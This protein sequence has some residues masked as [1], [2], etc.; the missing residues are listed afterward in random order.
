M[1][2]VAYLWNGLVIFHAV[3]VPFSVLM[4]LVERKDYRSLVSD[5][6]RVGAMIAWYLQVSKMVLG[7]TGAVAG[8]FGV[9][10]GVT[11]LV[12]LLTI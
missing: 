11:Y 12:K 7:C 6:G 2:V 5:R 9:V 8:F 1:S 4:A 3:V 10:F